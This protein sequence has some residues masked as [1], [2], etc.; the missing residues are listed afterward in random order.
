[1]NM[2]ARAEIVGLNAGGERICACAARIS[3]TEGTARELLEGAADPEKDRRL[4]GK[5]LGSGHKSV[6]EHIVLTLAFSNVSVYVEQFFIEFRLASFT[7]KSRR[8]VDFGHAGYYSPPELGGQALRLYR[9]YMDALFEGY[10]ALL[11]GGVPK[12]DARFLLPYS[13]CSNFYCTVNARE[14]IHMLREIKYGR[15]RDI[16]E[17]QGIAE[18][19]TDQLGALVPSVLAELNAPCRAEIPVPRG[20]AEPQSGEPCFVPGGESGAV[21]LVQAPAHPEELLRLAQ[22]IAHPGAQPVGPEALSGMPR[23]RE[24]ELL[25][26]TFRISDV[27]L[28]GITHFTRHRMQSLLI[29]PIE[30]LRD[31]RYILPETIRANPEAER[32]YRSAVERANAFLNA[33]GSRPE[34]RKYRYY[35]ALSGNL[36]DIAASVNARELLHF[37]QLR[38]CSRAQWE[39]RE[40]AVRMLELLRA[41]CP[42]LFDRFGPACFVLG[43]CPEGRLSCGRKDEV[44]ARFGRQIVGPSD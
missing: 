13:F 43:R 27:T 32:L 34:L 21:E 44:C 10:R 39:I 29:P 19:L 36:T 38:A 35:F 30:G 41:S 33:E 28:S 25:N 22:S 8:Y 9:E 42:T 14:L 18:Q 6:I 1:M 12:E 3:T 15:G 24:L 31:G 4:I 7:V 40:I 2:G 26:Y 16:L 11:D 5:V 23:P 17:L 20:D 37:M